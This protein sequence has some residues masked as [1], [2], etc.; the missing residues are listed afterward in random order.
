MQVEPCL[1]SALCI[2]NADAAHNITTEPTECLVGTA[3]RMLHLLSSSKEVPDM[4]SCC[5]AVL[6]GWPQRPP[7]GCGAS[8]GCDPRPD[9][10]RAAADTGHQSSSR[11]QQDSRAQGGQGPSRQDSASSCCC[12]SCCGSSRPSTAGGN[13]HAAARSHAVCQHRAVVKAGP[14]SSLAVAVGRCSTLCQGR[15]GSC[16]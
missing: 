13:R 12:F 5:P 8:A 4:C 1:P 3:I 10:T 16:A 14:G 7:R 15:A 11:A 6:P 9:N 2:M